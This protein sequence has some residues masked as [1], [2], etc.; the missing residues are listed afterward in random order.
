MYQA[1]PQNQPDPKADANA[2]APK[3]K[4]NRNRSRTRNRKRNRKRVLD[5]NMHTMETLLFKA[6]NVLIRKTHEPFQ[7]ELTNAFEATSKTMAK[8]IVR[9]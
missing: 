1:T 3:R 7:C 6:N 9:R 8:N 4:R 5:W 2:S